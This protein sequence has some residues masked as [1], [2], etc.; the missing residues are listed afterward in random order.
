MSGLNLSEVEI[1]RDL[2]NR[3]TQL[4]NM[5]SG[6]LQPVAD[7]MTAI[8][9]VQGLQSNFDIL[10]AGLDIDKVRDYN[11]VMESLVET[12]GELN[13]VLAE[14]NKGVFGGGTGVAA[15]DVLG[16][17]NTSSAGSAEGMNRLNTLMT[18]VLAVLQEIATDADR[19][20]RNTASSSNNIVNGN[21]TVM[22]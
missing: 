4:G 13:E 1:P 11:E 2:V 19:I 20:E 8:A 5:E 3:L 16:Q 6:G 18:Q 7:G 14:D 9:N 10:N 17:I 21:V 15:S 22:R 12:L